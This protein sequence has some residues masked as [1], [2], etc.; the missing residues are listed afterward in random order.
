MLI[1]IF[2]IDIFDPEFVNPGVTGSSDSLDSKLITGNTNPQ[3]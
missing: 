2:T 3:D 1:K